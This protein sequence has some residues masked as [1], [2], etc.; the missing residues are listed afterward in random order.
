MARGCFEA[1]GDRAGVEA[2]FSG[3]AEQ[4]EG[5]LIQLIVASADGRAGDQSE[6]G[7]ES[8]Q[9]VA[10]VSRPAR[11]VPILPIGLGLW[12]RIEQI[13]QLRGCWLGR[14]RCRPTIGSPT[15]EVTAPVVRWRQQDVAVDASAIELRAEPAGAVAYVPLFGP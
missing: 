1:M 6:L 14:Y 7:L 4:V 2:T 11:A 8:A 13:D 15:V 3:E 5:R 10:V 12:R 9:Q